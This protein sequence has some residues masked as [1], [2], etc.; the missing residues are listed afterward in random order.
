MIDYMTPLQISSHVMEPFTRITLRLSSTA[1]R[2]V[3]SNEETEYRREP[4]FYSRFF[5]FFYLVCIDPSV[6]ADRN[7]LQLPCNSVQVSSWRDTLPRCNIH[8]PVR[9]LRCE[10]VCAGRPAAVG[11]LWGVEY[12]FYFVLRIQGRGVEEEV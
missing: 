12:I 2:R 10:G 11:A 5:F 1:N 8:A 6:R 7:T 9:C 4:K 3:Y